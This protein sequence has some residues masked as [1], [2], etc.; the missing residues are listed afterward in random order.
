MLASRERRLNEINFIW[1]FREINESKWHDMYK[2]LLDYKRNYGHSFVPVNYK[3]NKRLGIWVATQRKLEASGKLGK[4]KKK[5][6]DQVGFVW[7]ADTQSALR[8]VYEATWNT[9]WKKLKAYK[10]TYG[11]CQVSLKIDSALQRWAS[12][13]RNLYL[14]GSL[15][16]KRIEKLN[17]INFPWSINEGYWMKMYKALTNFSSKFGHTRVP[18]LWAAN[19]PLAAWIYRTKLNKAELDTQKIKLLN[20]IGFDWSLSH[21][22][23]VSWEGMFDRLVRFRQEHGHTRVPVKWHEDRKLGKWVSRMRHIKANMPQERKSI[24]ESIEFDWGNQQNR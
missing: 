11:T 7:A 24:L 15:S 16:G 14:Q 13:Q 18:F 12:L 9:N 3:G 20:S 1:D 17:E 10:K 2:Q 23:V 5:K 6:L 22:T 21:K 4:I 8:S 19:P